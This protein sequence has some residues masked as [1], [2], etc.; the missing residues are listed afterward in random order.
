M[1]YHSWWPKQNVN[2]CYR[3]VTELF[4]KSSHIKLIGD[5]TELRDDMELWSGWQLHNAERT[6]ELWSCW[7]FIATVNKYSV[8]YSWCLNNCFRREFLS[9]LLAFGYVRH[10]YRLFTCCISSNVVL[11]V[12]YK[13]NVNPDELLWNK[14]EC[15]YRIYTAYTVAILCNVCARVWCNIIVNVTEGEGG[16]GKFRGEGR[17]FILTTE[18]EEWYPEKEI[19]R[20]KLK[21]PLQV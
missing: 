15:I 13:R 21:L 17:G 6:L 19:L 2:P 1:S 3:A 5:I 20:S 10:F 8:L 4:Q 11:C 16:L 14:V 7:H 18:M 9:D 12:L